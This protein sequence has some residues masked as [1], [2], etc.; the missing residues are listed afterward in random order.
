[1]AVKIKSGTCS[2]FNGFIIEVEVFISKGLPS[3]SIVGLPD[4]AVRESKERVRAAIINS[5]Y[6]FPMGR[7]TV[8]LAPADIKKIGSLLDLPI[9]I[10]ILIES[11]QISNN[12]LKDFLII[13]ELS[14]SGD[15][16]GVKGVLPIMMEGVER[17]IKNIIFPKK[18]INE[19]T[20]N[21]EITYYP[22]ND[23]KET[24][25][26]INSGNSISFKVRKNKLIKE[27]HPYTFDDIIGQENSKR[28]M[29]LSAAGKHNLLLFGKTGCGKTMLAKA[30]KSILSDLSRK[31]KIEIAKIYSIAGKLENNEMVTRP[32]RN[33]HHSI[34]K[35]ALIGGGNSVKP[36]EVTLA[37]G[38]ILFLD[39][40]LEFKK[41]ILELLR[42]PLEEG[43]ISINRGNI[44][45]VLPAKFI[46]IGATNLCP[47]GNEI[48]NDGLISSGCTC[49][50]GAKVRYTNKISKA[51]RDRI[52]IFNYVPPIKFTEINN[53][54]L[55]ISTKVMREKVRFAEEQQF[56]RL[57]DTRYTFNAEIK[58]KDIFELCRVSKKIMNLLENYFKIS[59]ASLRSY[60][61]VIKL[62]RTIADIEDN[63]DISESNIIE[64]IS[65]RRDFNGKII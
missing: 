64:A 32:F 9:A 18:N 40:I 26:F 60:G 58:G 47:C 27:K 29:L 38:G 63:K 5:G 48:I 6:K 16:K 49:S 25:S 37:H 56:E 33:P 54:N 13:G 42:E 51:L 34:T 59:G 61:K 12:D 20:Y 2:N 36:G 53:K 35:M 23:L 1:M 57:K 3:F 52:D 22:F 17:K 28:A 14:L 11:N 45:M 30:Y 7:I 46:L 24:T 31:E 10:G 65:F 19:C 44:A 41:G 21:N 15:I 50:E 62:A 8:S 39:E 43:N 4:T 55:R